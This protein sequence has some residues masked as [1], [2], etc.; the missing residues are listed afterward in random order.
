MSIYT[1]LTKFFR[2]TGKGIYNFSKGVMNVVTGGAIERAEDKIDAAKQAELEI[3]EANTQ[4][5][6]QA[7]QRAINKSE[8]ERN[9]DIANRQM[10]V[11]AQQ[12]SEQSRAGAI[13][14]FQAESAGEASLGASGMSAGSSPYM[15][16]ESQINE[17]SR[18][19]DSWFSG[20]K[21]GLSI[22]SLQA[23]GS[24][25]ASRYN[26]RASVANESLLRERASLAQEQVD[27]MW[28]SFITDTA[29]DIGAGL[30]STGLSAYSIGSSIEGLKTMAGSGGLSLGDSAKSV[31]KMA[32]QDSSSLFK[33]GGA[34]KYGEATGDMSQAKSLFASG[35]LYDLRQAAG[36]SAPFDMSKINNIT[37]KTKK[38]PI[39][40]IAGFFEPTQNAWETRL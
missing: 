26:E 15:A 38:S 12:I 28:S 6:L 21:E 9:A 33:L 24:L 29:L 32:Q 40:P 34:M 7:Q 39:V 4:A 11:E 1:G 20:A 18:K 2:K 25:E 17:A 31:F 5:D 22:A 3:K 19:I 30:L 14:K 37:F 16:L 13:E 23:G 10:S 8:A 27:D 35:G 36:V